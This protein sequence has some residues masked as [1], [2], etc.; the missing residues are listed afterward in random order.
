MTEHP[1]SPSTHASSPHGAQAP[2]AHLP[3]NDTEGRHPRRWLVLL[4]MTG[5]LSMIFVDM[6]VVGVALPS[7]GGSLGMGASG[8]AW[9]V[10]SYLLALASLVALGG[11]MGDLLGKVP[12]FI[13]GVAGFAAASVVCGMATD[14][15]MMIAGRVA[16]GLFACL[17]QPASSALVVGSFAPGERGKAM[18]AYVGIPM[19]FLALGPALGGW[20]VE[21]AG[22]R[23]VFLLNLPVAAMAIALTMVARPTD[24]RASD[25]RVD[26]Q[27]GALLL[28]GLVLLV[29]GMQELG[30]AVAS[31]AGTG[32]GESPALLGRG[33]A[34]VS[35][36]VGLAL[37]ALFVRMEWN[38]A[39]PLLRLRLFADHAL[40]GNALVI[41]CMQFSMTG[42]V[43]QGALYAQEV[44]G[45][46]PFQAGASIMPMLVPVLL[47]VHV[48][49][50]WYD[51][52][53]VRQPAVWGTALATLG[54]AVQ[55]IGMWMQ[56]YPVMVAGMAVMG[57]GI[58]FTMSP[59]NTDALARVGAEH[60]GQ[61]SGLMQTLRQVGATMGVAATASAAIAAQG[62]LESRRP[63]V[64]HAHVQAM[65]EGLRSEDGEARRRAENDPALV[66]VRDIVASS[67]AVGGG[68]SA[69]AT[70]AAWVCAVRLLPR[71]QRPVKSR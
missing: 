35:I 9:I 12:V 56:N 49:G 18:A 11:R 47:M 24:V 4:A 65:R 7:I 22:W 69:L 25:R 54:Q 66:S 43:I 46:Q 26:W 13:V 40:A 44:L 60:R 15:T 17:M 2:G 50:R 23:W 41:A 57:T 34:A 3:G 30:A 68:V 10:S 37:L 27:G 55:A 28:V 39:R 19:L 52:A 63:D 70:A 71:G 31:E 67:M 59:T 62:W 45:L 6:T 29:F 1:A 14:G 21:H 20:L 61:V 33:A 38:A 5:S 51:R 42:L 8:Q 32:Q 53:G 16:Q 64:T 36:A 58:A 48:A